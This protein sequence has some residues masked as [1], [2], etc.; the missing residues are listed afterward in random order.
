MKTRQDF[1]SN[2][3]SSSFTCIACG[4]TISGQDLDFSDYGFCTCVNDHT[5]CE[6]DLLQPLSEDEGEVVGIDEYGDEVGER[7][8]VPE[9]KCPVCSLTFLPESDLAAYILRKTGIARE[10][11]LAEVTKDEPRR[12]R[13]YDGEYLAFACEK[14]GLRILDILPE[15]R[16]RF[17]SYRVFSTFIYLE[18][19]VAKLEGFEGRFSSQDERIEKAER[20]LAAVEAKQ[21]AVVDCLAV[22][23]ARQKVRWQQEG[24]ERLVEQKA[25]LAENVAMA[26]AIEVAG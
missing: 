17:P 7:E 18:N 13:V 5:L 23:N 1:V 4:E 19:A 15:I 9:N 26:K 16:G 20:E 2:S 6:G 12:K 25:K 10:D 8:A 24:R 21:G 14:A 22:S 3:S 11:A